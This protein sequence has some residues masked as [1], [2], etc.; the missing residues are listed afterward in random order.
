MA[1]GLD[2][3]PLPREQINTGQYFGAS[4]ARAV[5][6]CLRPQRAPEVVISQNG[7][8]QQLRLFAGLLVNFDFAQLPFT[9]GCAL[10][11]PRLV[12]CL[13]P[14]RGRRPAMAALRDWP[15]LDE[16]IYRF[17]ITPGRPLSIHFVAGGET[18]V[19]LDEDVFVTPGSIHFS[20]AG[21]INYVT[22]VLP[23]EVSG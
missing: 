6:C 9:T 4:L 2:G 13:I 5:H 14:W 8:S 16:L 7:H 17:E 21:F 10:D 1:D 22:G 23:R 18:V 19:A 12:L 3:P 11:E 15:H 20:V